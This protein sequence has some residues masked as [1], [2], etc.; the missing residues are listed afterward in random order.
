[1][2]QVHQVKLASQVELGLR[3]SVEVQVQLAL[4]V[5]QDFKEH[6]DRMEQL[7]LLDQREHK[8]IQDQQD[9]KDQMETLVPQDLLDNLDH[10]E[11]QDLM[12]LLEAQ[13]HQEPRVNQDH[14]VHLVM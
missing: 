14:L 7:G 3:D 9:L 10:L 12:V 8:V 4:Q 11:H 13:D 5:T 1:V 6:P 2:L